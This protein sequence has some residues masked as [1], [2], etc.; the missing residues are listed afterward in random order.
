M[1]SRRVGTGLP[2]TTPN[3]T[4]ATADAQVRVVLRP[5]GTPLPLG[6]LAQAVASF[7]LGGVQLGWVPTSQSHHVAWAVLVLT[8][9]LQ[10]TASVLGFLARDPVAGTGPALLS[11]AWAATAV[12]ILVTPPGSADAGLGLVLLGLAVVL[13]VPTAAGLSKLAVAAVL[14]LSAVRFGTTG[15]EELTASTAW[16]HVA[17]W[18]GLVLAA[19][20]T[21]AALALEL[22]AGWGGTVLP[23]GRLGPARDH[24]EPGIREVL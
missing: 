12:N 1:S 20:S 2:M 24:G 5:I 6:L 14:L 11:G 23:V 7:S 10:L 8:V 18:A 21:Y 9:P 15:I 19:T 3:P 17:G 22:E 16:Q 13:L 4:S